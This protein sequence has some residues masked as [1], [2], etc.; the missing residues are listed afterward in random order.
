MAAAVDDNNDDEHS[1]GI[2]KW[3]P[4]GVRTKSR[5]G[6]FPGGQW[7]KIRCCHCCGS[8]HCCGAGS[9]PGPETSYAMGTAEKKEVGTK[10]RR[11]KKLVFAGACEKP[12]PAG[13]DPG[14]SWELSGGGLG[15][16]I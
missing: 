9:V 13:G 15:G 5:H 10:L 2:V 6:E 3:L 12:C 8:G 16:H 4:G 11:G 7:L 14:R 1:Q